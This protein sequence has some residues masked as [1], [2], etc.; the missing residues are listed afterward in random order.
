MLRVKNDQTKCYVVLTSLRSSAK[1]NWYFDSGR[2][3]HMASERNY[4]FYLK[5]I[6]SRKVTFG[7]G[8]ASKIIG[9][10]K[11]NYPGLPSLNDVMLTEG[12]TASLI[13]FN[14][15]CDQGINMSFT[16]H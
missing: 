8:V 11:L 4:L 5:P 14:Q 13:C 16:K 15:L 3:R 7:D 1:G 2:S 12:L 9:K 10:G 6:N